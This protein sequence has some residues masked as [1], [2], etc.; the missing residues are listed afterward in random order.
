MSNV[1]N[2]FEQVGDRLV[3]GGEI[4]FK[5]GAD[6]SG[7]PSDSSFY[8]LDLEGLDVSGVMDKPMDITAQFPLEVFEQAVVGAKPVLFRNANLNGYKYSVLSCCT[9]GENMIVGMGGM[10][11]DL[12][13][14]LFTIVTVILFRDDNRIYLR[15]NSNERLAALLGASNESVEPGETERGAS[16]VSELAKKK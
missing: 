9:D 15:T 1:K 13:G 10:P 12:T 11:F 5:E 3:I 14:R 4:A 2:Y 6:V 7:F 16:V 8:V